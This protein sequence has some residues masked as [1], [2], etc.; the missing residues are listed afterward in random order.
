MK[1]EAVK[2]LIREYNEGTL[3]PEQKAKLESWYI[4]QAANSKAEL[5]GGKEEE[6]IQL[7]R[8]GRWP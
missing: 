5:S 6:L 4:S 3:S 2:S 1:E 8:G 7:R